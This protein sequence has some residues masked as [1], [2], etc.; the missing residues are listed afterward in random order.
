MTPEQK[1]RRK[2]LD[3][4]SRSMD[5]PIESRLE[6]GTAGRLMNLIRAR[7]GKVSPESREAI[8]TYIRAAYVA[9]TSEN[10][11]TRKEHAA[12]AIAA[13]REA[14]TENETI[15]TVH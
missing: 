7:D 1:A 14:M 8:L 6:Q 11:N 12:T 13:L 5:L 2:K 3:E 9:R 15:Q 10:P 4:F